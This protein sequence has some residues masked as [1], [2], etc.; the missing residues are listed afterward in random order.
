MP[1]TIVQP[2]SI[3]NNMYQWITFM[4]PISSGSRWH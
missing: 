1:Q 2:S 3:A 4:I